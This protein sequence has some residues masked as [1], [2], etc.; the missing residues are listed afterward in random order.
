MIEGGQHADGA[1][2]V[3]VLLDQT[4][5]GSETAGDILNE[6]PVQHVHNSGGSRCS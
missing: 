1:R 5:V 6:A 2:D 4:G 3:P